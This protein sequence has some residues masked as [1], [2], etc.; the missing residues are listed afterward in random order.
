MLTEERSW[1]PTKIDANE[2]V[3]MQVRIFD[4]DTKKPVE[5]CELTFRK[6]DIQ[7]GS[8]P[9]LNM[10]GIYLKG[11]LQSIDADIS[12][13]AVLAFDGREATLEKIRVSG[14]PIERYTTI[15]HREDGVDF[16]FENHFA[17]HD[18]DPH[19]V[20]KV[21]HYTIFLDQSM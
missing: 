15:Y 10:H 20:S 1:S 6:K 17:R 14:R 16:E 3:T 11:R 18:M 4:K 12:G 2:P 13:R 8:L 5:D 7:L 19:L 21:Q 9:M